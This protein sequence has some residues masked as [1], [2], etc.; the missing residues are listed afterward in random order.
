[1]RKVRQNEQNC[2]DGAANDP[3]RKRREFTIPTNK[4]SEQPLPTT[5]KK[6]KPTRLRSGE[7]RHEAVH[8]RGSTKSI[9]T[10]HHF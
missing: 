10:R 6:L 3:R 9:R 2:R 5:A 8:H 1:M 4:I 7:S